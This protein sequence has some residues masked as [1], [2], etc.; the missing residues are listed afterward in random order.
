[1]A[2]SLQKIWLNDV[3]TDETKKITINDR[4][5]LLGDGAFETFLIRNGA[6]VF[7]GAHLARLAAGLDLLRIPRSALENIGPVFHELARLNDCL[8][9]DAVGRL[10]VTRGDGARGLVSPDENLQEPTILATVAAAP[11]TKKRYLK[12]HVSQRVRD[13]RSVTSSFKSL[14]GYAE[15]QMARFEAADASCDDALLVNS[16]DRI[17]CAS[18]ANVFVI[19][20]DGIVRTPPTREG[21]M[22]GVVRNLLIDVA[23]YHGI[24]I[25]ESPIEPEALTSARCLFLTNSM[26]GVVQAYTEG[27]CSKPNE[28]VSQLARLYQTEVEK[29]L[30]TGRLSR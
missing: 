5:I 1:M 20:S 9:K 7:L 16:F 30:A 8:N 27:T 29:S 18:T 3:Y 13:S 22:P 14:S 11:A 25:E 12:L 19:G 10:T 26:I 21:A 28:T 24:A 23:M 17:A 15:N 6:P 4:G 2:N